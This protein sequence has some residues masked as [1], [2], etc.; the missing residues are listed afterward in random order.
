MRQLIGRV[1]QE[2]NVGSRLLFVWSGLV[3]P[4]SV[5]FK[6]LP[7][8]NKCKMLISKKTNDQITLK[9]QVVTQTYV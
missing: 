9:I 1:W 2:D 3:I 8:I 6:Q 7:N 4:K 5:C